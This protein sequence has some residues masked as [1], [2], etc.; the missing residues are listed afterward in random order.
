MRTPKASGHSI[1]ARNHKKYFLNQNVTI[2]QIILYVLT[3]HQIEYNFQALKLAFASNPER[4]PPMKHGNYLKTFVSK[5]IS[6][7]FNNQGFSCA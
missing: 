4:L 3:V 2:R 7:K 5:T 1:A 6:S